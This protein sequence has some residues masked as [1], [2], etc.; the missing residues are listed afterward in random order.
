VLAVSSEIVPALFYFRPGH[1]SQARELLEPAILALHESP[2]GQQVLTVFQCD[3]MVKLPVS[4]LDAT[5]ELLAEHDRLQK[6][7]TNTV[8]QASAIETSEHAPNGNP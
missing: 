4:C 1:T 7:S 2:A 5:R 6:L 8:A 3:K